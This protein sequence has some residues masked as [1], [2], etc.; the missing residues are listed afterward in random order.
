MEPKAKKAY[1]ILSIISIL[2]AGVV[3]LL[4]F[5]NFANPVIVIV[6]TAI[7]VMLIISIM[8]V[9]FVRIRQKERADFVLAKKYRPFD[10][11]AT[12]YKEYDPSKANVSKEAIFCQYCEARMEYNEDVCSNCGK[13]KDRFAGTPLT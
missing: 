10:E 3:V 13:K 12:E 6:P 9:V 5:L 4:A 7:G 2:L 11:D 8:W 1:F